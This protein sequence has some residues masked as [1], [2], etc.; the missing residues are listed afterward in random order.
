VPP[1]T[2]SIVI[3]TYDRPQEVVDC[4]RAIAAVDY[5]HE[6]F[7]VVVV[8][9]GFGLEAARLR[10]RAVR[11]HAVRGPQDVRESRDVCGID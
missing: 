7:E 1:P 3:A 8:D 5:P 9:D 2:F 4:P 6:R 10:R 11:P